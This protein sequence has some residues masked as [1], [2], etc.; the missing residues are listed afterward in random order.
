MNAKNMRIVGILVGVVMLLVGSQVKRNWV[1]GLLLG[2]GVFQVVGNLLA[3]NQVYEVLEAQI[4][5]QIN[6]E[7]NEELSEQINANEGQM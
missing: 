3:D 6:Q 1:K 2:F 7:L 4:N 5:E